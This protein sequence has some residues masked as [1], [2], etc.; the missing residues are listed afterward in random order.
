MDGERMVYLSGQVKFSVSWFNVLDHI[1]DDHLLAQP[2]LVICSG[3][4]IKCSLT[5][6]ANWK[7]R[8]CSFGSVGMAEQSKLEQNQVNEWP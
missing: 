7:A 5:A 4:G 6:F 3:L 2:Y 8:A 1:P